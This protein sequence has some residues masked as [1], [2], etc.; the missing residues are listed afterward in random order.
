[1]RELTVLVTGATGLLGPYIV[2]A[3]RAPGPHAEQH[4]GPVNAYGRTKL[5]GERPVRDRDDRGLVVRTNWFAPSRTPGRQSLSDFVAEA[6][7]VSRPIVLFEDV[8]FSP[9]HVTTLAALLVELV[10]SGASGVFNA[11]AGDVTSKAE[12]AF[13][14][15]RHLGLDPSNASVGRSSDMPRR[16]LRPHDLRLD[17]LLLEDRLRRSLPS[18]RDEVQKL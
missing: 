3:F 14:V 18:L 10:A 16:A 2:A 9:L 8:R 11:G 1:M 5:A 15:A 13:E 4:T 12:F 17:V 6:M 7:R